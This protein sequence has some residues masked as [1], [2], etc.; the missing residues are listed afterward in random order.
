MEDN[1]K[2]TNEKETFK[3]KRMKVNRT[4]NLTKLDGQWYNIW[5][6]IWETKSYEGKET[7]WLWKDKIIK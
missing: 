2:D 4:F 3:I 6:I 5:K 1:H 7:H